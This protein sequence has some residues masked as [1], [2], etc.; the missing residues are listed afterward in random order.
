MEIKLDVLVSTCIKQRKPWPRISWVGQEKEAVFLLDGKDINEINLSSGKTKKKI[1]LLQS[2]LKN[3]VVLTTSGNA[4]WLAGILTTGELFL[5]N[6][7]QD[8]LKI[9]PAIEESKKV[10][11]GAQECLMRLYLYVS[12]DGRKVLLTTPTACAFLWESTEHENTPS[13]KNSPSGHWTQILT[14]ESV[15]L[16]STEEKEIGV[17]AAFIQNEVLGDCCLCSFVFYSGECLMLTFLIL[18]WH[19]NTFKNVSFLPYQI[20]WVQQT[21]SLVNLVPRCVSVK[22]RGAL[23]CAFARDGLLLAVAVNQTDPKATQVLFLNTLN[24]VTVSGSLKGCSS[25]SSVTPSRFIRSYWVGDM[26]WTPD[27]LFLACMLKRGCLVLLTCMG[28]LLTLTASGCSVEF[29]P[30]QFIPFHPLITYSQ[31]LGSSDS[32]RDLLRQRF[33]VASHPRLPYLIVSDGYVITLLRFPNNFSPSGFM[34]SLL[35]DSTQQLE[36]VRQNLLNFKCKGRSQY[37]RSLL[38]LKASLLKQVQNQSSIFSTI[39][40]F[41]EEDTTEMNEKTMDLLVLNSIFPL[42]VKLCMFKDLEEESDNE[43][44]FYS[45][46]S[47]FCNQRIY[48]SVGKADEGCLEFASMFDTIHAEDDIE[49]K[50]KSSLELYSIQKNLLG[51][52]QIGT[53]KKIEEKD[54]LLNYTVNCIIH[55]FSIV[56]FV[57]CT[58]LRQDASLNKSAKNTQWMHFVLKYFQQCLTVLYWHSRAGVTGHVAKLTLE[59]LKLMFIQQQDQLFSKNLL[60]CFCLLKMVSHTLSRVCVLHYENFFAS[61]D[62]NTLVELDSLTVPVF[63]VLD[64]NTTQQFSSLKSLLQECPQVN[65]DAKTEKRLTVLWQLLYKKVVWYQVQLKRKVSKN[66]EEVSVVSLLLSHIQA[67]IQSSGVTL[68]QRLKINSVSGEE[69]FLLGSYRESVDIWKRSLCELKTKGGKRACFLQRRYCLAILFCHLYQ[70]NMCEAQGLCDHLVREILRRSQLSTGQM[71]E[72]SD[73]GCFQHELWMVTSIHTDAAMAVIQS[74]ARFM[75]AYF[76]KQLLYIFPPHNVDILHPLHIKQDLPRRIIPLQHCLVTRAVRDQKLSSVWT[77]EYALDLFFVGGLIPEAVWLAH[78]L[79]DWK[80]SVS[81]GLAYQ[82]YCQNSEELSRMKKPECHLPLSLLPMQTFQEKL[83][84][85]L[86]QP[87][88]SETSGHIKYKMFTDPIEEEDA[89]VLYSSIQELLKAA[90]MADVDILSETF[91]LLMDSA[92]DLCK[93]FYGLVPVGLCL[94]APP[95]YCPQPASLSDEDSDDIL[96]KTEKEVRQKVSGVL[97]RIIL[98]FR[99]AH[100]SCSAAQWYITQLKWARKVMQKIR[101]KG[102]LPLLS[103]FPETL[104]RYCNFH[105]A[106]YGSTS[107]GAHQFDDITCKILGW[108]REFC[109]LCWMF[110]VREKLSDNCRRYQTAREN[111]NNIKDPNKNG[112]D[113]YTV[114]NCLNAVEW[115]CRMLPFCRFMNVEEIVQDVILSLLGELPPVKKVA[116]IFVK[117]FPNPEDVRVPLRDKYHGLQ[118]RLRCSTVKEGPESEEI[119]SVVIQAAEEVRKKALR[120]VV[121]NIGPIEVNIWEPVEEAASNDEEHCYDRFSLGTSL[122]TSTLTDVGNPQVYND[123]DTADALSD[124]LFTEETRPQTPSFPRE[125]ELQRQ[126][127][128]GNK[129]TTHKIKA[130]NCKTKHKDKVCRRDRL[131]QHNLP[132]VGAW[133]FERDDDEYVRFLELFLSYVLERDL[134]KYSDLGIP[135][136][137]SFSGLLRE[138]E[139]NSLFFDVH[140]AL[141]RRQNKTRSQSVFRAGSCYTVTL[142]SC[143]PEKL[144]ACNENKN[145]LEKPTIVQSVGQTTEPSVCNLKKGLQEGLFGLKYKSVYRA[146]TD[147]QG[148]SVAQASHTFCNRTSSTLQTQA[149]PKYVYKT[150]DVVGIVPAEELPIDLMGKLSNISKL[151]EWM[152]RWSDKRLLCRSNKQDSLEETLPKIHL[153][154]SSAAVLTSFWLLEQLFGNRTQT[155]SIKCK[156]PDDQYLKEI[157]P[158]SEA[159]SG[160]EE[161]SSVNEGCSTVASSPLDVQI[162]Q[163]YDNLCESDLG[164]STKS[165]YFYKRKINHGN[166][167]VPYITEDLNEVGPFIQQELD[168]TSEQE[169][170]EEPY[171]TSKSSNSSVKIRPLKHQREQSAI[172]WDSTKQI[173]EEAKVCS[174]KM[175][176]VAISAVDSVQEDPNMEETKEEKAEQNIMTEVVTSTLS[177]SFSLKQDADV[178]SSADTV[179]DSQPSETAVS[180]VSSLASHTSVC[181]KKREVKEEVPREEKPSTSETVRHMLQD[182]M[183][184]LVQ[185]QQINFMSLMQLVQSSFTNVPNVQ[186]VLQQHQLVHL[187]G[188]QPAHTAKSNA[189]PKTQVPTQEEKG[190]TGQESSVFQPRKSVEDESNDG[191]IKNHLD[192]G[193]SLTLFESSSKETGLMSPSQDLHSSVPTKPLHLLAPSS[194]IQKKVKLIPVE[195]KISYSNGFPLLKLESSYRVKPAFLHPTEMPSAFARPPPVPRVA[196]SSSDSLWDHQSSY[197]PR[198][199]KAE[200]DFHRSR[201]NPEIS[202]QKHEEKERWAE[203]VREGP[204]KHLNSDQR[205]GQQEDSPQPQFPENVNVFKMLT[206]QNLAAIPL[207]HLQLDPVP[208]VPPAVRQPVTTPLIPGKPAAKAADSRETQWDA[209]ISLLQI[210]LPQKKKASNL[211]PLR[212]IIAF[213]QCHKHHSVHSSSFGQDQTKP[214][215]LLRTDVEPFEHRDVQ[216]KRKSKKRRSKKQLKEK[217]DKKKPSVSFRPDDSII[218]ISDTAVASESETG[219]HKPKSTSYVQDGFFMSTDAVDKASIT[220][221]DLHYLASVG[222]KPT[223]TQ[224]ASTNTNPVLKSYQ[225]HGISGQ[226]EVSKVQENKLVTSVPA[227]ESSSSS[228]ILLPDMYLNLSFPTEVNEKHLPSLLSDAPDLHK[229]EYISV[230]D[231]EDSDI[232]SN[233]PMKPESAE[234]IAAEQQN[235]KLEIPSTAELHHTAASVTNAIPPGALQK[236]DDHEKNMSNK[237]QK[238]DKSDSA[239][240]IVTWNIAHEDGGTLPSSGLPPKLIEKEYFST[241]QK[242]MDMQ[243]RVL[244]NIV[245]NME[246]DFRNSKMLVKLIEDFEM[247]ADSDLG[248]KP[249]VSEA[250]GVIGAESEDHLMGMIF[251]DVIDDQKESLTLKYPMPS[252]TTVDAH[253]S[254]SSA[255]ASKFPSGLK[256]PSDGEISLGEEAVLFLPRQP[257]CSSVASSEFRASSEYLDSS[258][259]HICRDL[260]PSSS[261]DPLQIAGLS[262]VTDIGNDRVVESE[263]SLLELDFARTQ[264]KKTFRVLDSAS[265]HSQRTEKERKEIQTWMKRK[266]KERMKEYLKKLDEQRQKEHHPFNLRKNVHHN[267]T[268]KDIRVF[269]KKK[270]EKDKALLSEHH[271]IRVSEALSLMNEM[272]SETMASPASDHRTLSSTRSAQSYQRRKVASSTGGHLKSPVLA[273]RSRTAAKPGFGQKVQRFTP[274][275]GLTQS[276]GNACMLLQKSTSRRRLRNA[277]NGSVKTRHSAECRVSRSS[278]QK[279]PQVATAVQTEGVDPDSDRDVVSPWTVPDDIQRILQDT[280]DSMFQ[281]SAVHRMNFSPLGSI[282]SDSVSESTGSILSKLDWNAVEAMIA[283]VEDK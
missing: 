65:H 267:P 43:K 19:E 243:L 177:H 120:R 227:S 68:E 276:R 62:S 26:S 266:Q 44:Q 244:E 2:L 16:P 206:T 18:R 107:S 35:L 215:Q 52:W 5:W 67:T 102:S 173:P 145:I 106:L 59:T 210:N 129:Y 160:A 188:S 200:E 88:T 220:S 15:I 261:E 71:E 57:K 97:Q 4:V 69:Q 205:E 38:S 181:A 251:E 100:C 162:V 280:H 54:A 105:T 12:G 235:E 137:T 77:A 152:I 233:L 195:K 116:E 165:K 118:Q 169:F 83:Q 268:S 156:H 264:A 250:A 270:E 281:A 208:R 135:F 178:P 219:D 34:R 241:K 50:D 86:G 269:Q 36:K 72:F 185:L 140:T 174:P 226:N 139:L 207:L 143:D 138:H 49:E 90:V 260:C 273:E 171:E 272:L 176:Q 132:V 277:T 212:D 158:L 248:A 98:L 142:A 74:M 64:D 199:C 80:L 203:T 197:A 45:S 48:S 53:S 202:R 231:I 110:H 123:A 161:E 20:Q 236:Q 214:I 186:Q 47:S 221:A 225:D 149:I 271:R 222:K 41:L 24:F 180:T 32:E 122:S 282:N 131:N 40:R 172:P 179:S 13:G 56:Q 204:P 25:K 262:D 144:S 175:K 61:P 60:A 213:E 141:K 259:S 155:R 239:T 1:P 283:D 121:K 136:L 256:S 237:L 27:S 257:Y 91:Q 229:R 189:S 101:M 51:A 14:D 29:G 7:D 66:A 255:L 166:N 130:P 111:I 192:K 28:E 127:E 76:T 30:A 234:E 148:V 146:Q 201:Y 6:K 275:L 99:A 150:L 84:S 168:V 11:A 9:V 249:A 194:D 119:M 184:K 159:Q 258:S 134:I 154:T 167:S 252:S 278:T 3:V 103:P 117:A 63:L 46:T 87:V 113:A 82:L 124:A 242:E 238:K 109:A 73:I 17:D 10:V 93:K 108:F 240:D 125:N 153:K 23:L 230:I 253:S 182:E 196:W 209:G 211:I 151:L 126:R 70:Y 191:R 274:A 31:S 224:D 39:P 216:N 55:F 78:T 147:S 89:D 157:A 96:L 114:E 183:F 85:L 133:E 232:L 228:E 246:Q 218:S 112:Y 92:K 115:A 170:F 79:G 37:L 33:S 247:A 254:A 263:T 42:T 187:A 245:E 164:M 75:A 163:V 265:G 81:I 193:S 104:L 8:C 279:P 190:K 22:S 94:P 198:K 58:L 217:E 21:C 95:L 128:I 223:E